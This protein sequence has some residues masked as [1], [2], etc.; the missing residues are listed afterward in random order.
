MFLLTIYNTITYF[1]YNII[2]EQFTD[3]KSL[4]ASID[5]DRINQEKLEKKEKERDKLQEEYQR[6]TKA[7]S[8]KDASNL[9]ID[10]IS[11]TKVN[12]KKYIQI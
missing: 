6:L 8:P 1:V 2:F 12:I 4:F 9:I 7:I 11:K 3:L 10:F 5:S